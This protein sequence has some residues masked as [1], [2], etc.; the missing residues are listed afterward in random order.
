M[1][2]NKASVTIYFIFA[3]VLIISITFSVTELIRMKGQKL[4]LKL[5]TNSALDSYFSL[6]HRKLYEYY[7]IYGIEYLDD[8]QIKNEY[9]SYFSPY[10]IDTYT[11]KYLKNYFVGEI[12]NNNINISYK[13]IIDNDYFERQ[14]VKF[15]KF[16]LIGKTL[17]IFGEK[18]NINE[19]FDLSKIE[20]TVKNVIELSSKKEIYKDIDMRYF[21][22]KNHINKI[23]SNIKNII[24][25]VKRLNQ[26]I[27]N[28]SNFDTNGSLNTAKRVLKNLVE[29]DD[30]IKSSLNSITT[31]FET[32]K[33]FKKCI[34]NNRKK[35]NDDKVDKWEFDEETVQFIE[36]EFNEFEKLTN[37]YE[38]KNSI[39][40]NLK[41]QIILKMN[42]LSYIY[43][44]F[45]KE[46]NELENLTELLKEEQKKKND[47]KDLDYIED[48][49]ND[50]KNI[51]KDISDYAKELK[52][53]F[54]GI[55]LEELNIT[56]SNEDSNNNENKL[57][58]I[59]NLLKGNI[60]D[61]V[62]DENMKQNINTKKNIYENF[63]VDSNINFIDKILM[64][65]YILTYFNDFYKK[66]SGKIVNSGSDLL[67]V[68]RILKGKDNDKENLNDVINDILLIRFT[69]NM[70]YLYKNTEKR[71]LARNFT[72]ILFSAFS[73]LA[74]EI[75]FILVLTAWGISQSI[76][77]IKDLLKFKKVPLI[78]DDTTFKVSLSNIFNTNNLQ[79]TDNIEEGLSY[80]DYLRILLY[81]TNQKTINSNMIGVIENN[82]KTTQENF[83]IKKMLYSMTIKNKMKFEHL[84][85]KFIIFNDSIVELY[86]K[87]FLGVDSFYDFLNL[88]K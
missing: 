81:K 11:E 74:S 79:N 6:Y 68:E 20:D 57:T 53:D 67:E 56:V 16:D 76:V 66:N 51:K 17:E 49:K 63:S 21:D 38:M 71:Q 23:E 42:E 43:N 35:F 25:R 13:N 37:E 73:P 86:D 60:I 22:F 4:Y 39:I 27:N 15:E 33:D 5:A 31:Y 9:I 72:Q 3:I 75:M 29:I 26:N 45:S 44:E 36:E 88:K 48:L 12:D 65:E 77:D 40:L 34:E 32:L 14:I 41:N 30:D 64:G 58:N 2:E 61:I 78:H 8:E 46:V 84:F 10:Y 54:V 85:T 50:I 28:N 55:D 24:I 82:I 70:I 19:N 7:R 80:N 18:F 59:K 62:L 87:Y 1:T 69:M 83:N 52:N 47:E